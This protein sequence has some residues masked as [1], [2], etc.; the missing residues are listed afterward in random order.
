MEI[1]P[2]I[3]IDATEGRLNAAE[4][5][6]LIRHIRGLHLTDLLER[7]GQAR[8]NLTGDGIVIGN[9]NVNVVIKGDLGRVLSD[10]IAR[11]QAL[12]QLPPPVGDFVGRRVEIER[13]ET[14]LRAEAAVVGIYGMGG[15]GKTE[16]ALHAANSFR[17]K[18]SDGQLMVNMRGTDEKPRAPRDALSEC[19]RALVGFE[20]KL[21]DDLEEL[22]KLYLSLLSDKAILVCLDNAADSTQVSS[23]RPP[24]TCG[25]I[26]TSRSPIVLPAITNIPLCELSPT[27]A[28]DL[29]LLIAAGIDHSVADT[30]CKLCGYLPLAIRAAGSVLAVTADLDASDFASQLRDER[31]RLEK[32]GTEGVDIGVEASFNLSYA[33]LSPDCS[34][35]F[36]QLAIFPSS[37][38]SSAQEFVCKD[39]Q[40]KRLTELVRRS[41][42]LFDKNTKRYRL[43]ELMRVF[44]KS[45]VNSEET[46]LAALR[47]AQ[48]YLNVLRD[49]NQLYLKSGQDHSLG[50]EH[51]NQE[52]DNI[53]AGRAWS[54]DHA[55]ASDEAA[56][57]CWSYTS[58]GGNILLNNLPHGE[59]GGW[60]EESISIAKHSNNRAGE[61]GPLTLLGLVQQSVGA[62]NAAEG[63]FRAAIAVAQE[64]KDSRGAA[65]VYHHLGRALSDTGRL[66]EAIENFERAKKLWCDLGE[67]ENEGKIVSDIGLAYSALRETSRAIQHLD[68]VLENAR[69]DQNRLDE[70]NALAN[71]SN[72]YSKRNRQKGIELSEQAA[73]IFEQLGYRH[74]AAQ[75]LASS[76]LWLVDIG[77]STKGIQRIEQSISTLN[78]IG[79]RDLEVLAVGQLGEAYMTLKDPDNAIIAFDRQLELARE[80]G[81]FHREANALG[82]KAIMLVDLGQIDSAIIAFD[83]ARRVAQLTGNL[84]HEF[85]TL[86]KS[87]EAYAKGGKRDEAVKAFEDQVQIGKSMGIVS[88]EL[89]ALKH[90]ADSYASWGDV[91]RAREY[92]QTRVTV[93]EKS[94][95]SHDYPDSDFEFAEFLA[96]TADYDG[97]IGHAE[98]AAAAFE[99]NR[100]PSCAGKVRQKIEEWRRSADSLAS[101]RA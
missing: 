95:D 52:I 17:A 63:H 77:E 55:E 30:I 79:D 97:A 29:L 54:S 35:T 56:S 26:I 1:T 81:D 83:D 48:H 18:F 28:R 87:G 20:R 58:W 80:I 67:H 7:I 57:I 15:M 60:C 43:H 19:V 51:F 101:A 6:R 47:F 71:L 84:N 99:R 100:D 50:V 2:E 49:A 70:A 34:S 93:S 65:T 38:D 92:M 27:E 21:P 24:T 86:C 23:L 4:Y 59:L 25:M 44:S 33:R 89:H 36:K 96:L 41:L 8:I 37:F 76:G 42:V 39:E 74:W 68:L 91:D 32:L 40:H 3:L 85:N 10:A 98:N 53:R 69:K 5:A 88:K 22:E 16:L 82:D 45:L 94:K 13:I 11:G 31:T 64:T 66:Y 62:Y 90:L 14:A 78:E 72:V 61:L 12:F 9:N 75:A 46:S 73:E